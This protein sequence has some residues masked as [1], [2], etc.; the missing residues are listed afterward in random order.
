MRNAWCL[1]IG[2]AAFSIGA[3]ACGAR[4]SLLGEEGGGSTASESVSQSASGSTSASGNSGGGGAGGAAPLCKPATTDVFDPGE[5]YVVSTYAASP[6][7]AIAHWCAMDQAVAGFDH[8]T[9]GTIRPTDGRFVYPRVPQASEF[10]CDA[11]PFTGA[12]P[13]E[14]EANDVP[15]A[16]ACDIERLMVAPEGYA[17]VQ[18][19]ADLNWYD[20]NGN[21]VWLSTFN[22][23]DPRILGYGGLAISYADTILNLATGASTPIAPLTAGGASIYVARAT[24]D[25]FF[26]V[27]LRDDAFE[28][29]HVAPDGSST[30]LGTYADPPSSVSIGV[31]TAL[32]AHNALIQTGSEPPFGIITRRT[33]DGVFEIVYHEAD[34]PNGPTV[35]ILLT[36]P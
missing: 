9:F 20:L 30:L 25:G 35:G 21:L 36:G 17:I 8:H 31:D 14:P 13:P 33:I 15:I 16:L 10:R 23:N 29:H 27:A 22:G 11:C 28:L 4:S 5:V 24:P 6:T 34:H 18:C 3:L 12:W 32:D 26:A 1:A 19:D 7:K 2:S